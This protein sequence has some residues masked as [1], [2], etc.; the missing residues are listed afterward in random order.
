[1]PY[2]LNVLFR[3]LCVWVPGTDTTKIQEWFGAFLVNAGAKI[4]DDLDNDPRLNQHFPLVRFD[5]KNLKNAPNKVDDIK[6]LWALDHEDVVIKPTQSAGPPLSVARQGNKDL[7]ELLSGGELLPDCLQATPTEGHVIARVHLMEGSLYADKLS[8]I[9]NKP[10][11]VQ[12]FPKQA[13][14]VEKVIATG[15][16]LQMNELQGDLILR[17]RA[18]DTKSSRELIFADPGNGNSITIEI[19]NL[20]ADELME[21]SSRLPGVDEDF[22]LNYLPSK[23]GHSR[24][25]KHQ[26]L[27]L[28][29]ATHFDPDGDGGGE[30]ARCT[31][32]QSSPLTD[33]QRAVLVKV[34]KSI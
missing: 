12:F 6:G 21:V 31:A 25:V 7:S 30:F 5:L 9:N 19:L 14:K 24:V 17:A 1:M 20:C 2:T 11:I 3:G 33:A 32:P 22:R 26:S 15:V 27:P 28:P 13:S 29:V 23:D 4:M 34:A 8:N 16:A 18:F 10:I